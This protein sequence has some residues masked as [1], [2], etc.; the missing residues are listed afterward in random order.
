MSAGRSRIQRK[1]ATRSTAHSGTLALALSLSRALPACLPA[2]TASWLR[3]ASMV[4][5]LRRAHCD[6]SSL[7][8]E[9]LAEHL[10]R[11]CTS[12]W[13]TWLAR[14]LLRAPS[15]NRLVQQSPLPDAQ[16]P[17][18]PT[19]QS[20][21][22]QRRALGSSRSTAAR[23]STRHAAHPPDLAS[24]PCRAASD[25][26]TAASLPTLQLALSTGARCDLCC[27]C[28]CCRRCCIHC[29]SPAQTHLNEA[30]NSEG[31]Y[32]HAKGVFYSL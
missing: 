4:M 27:H 16:R 3:F 26:T 11:R 12:T 7:G 23:R 28:C 29:C 5:Q 17:P 2:S 24:R 9:A 1:H 30:S 10:I 15:T 22:E 25:L 19:L 20:S 21:S 32:F 18:M 6:R 14:M 8:P 31:R 13:N